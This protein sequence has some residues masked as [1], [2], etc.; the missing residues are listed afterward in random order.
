MTENFYKW[1]SAKCCRCTCQVWGS[2]TEFGQHKTEWCSTRFTTKLIVEKLNQ[3][4]SY[5]VITSSAGITCSPPALLMV[6]QM[7]QFF[8]ASSECLRLIFESSRE[9]ISCSR[10]WLTC[11]ADWAASGL[12][13]LICCCSR[14]RQEMLGIQ[15]RMSIPFRNSICPW[16]RLQMA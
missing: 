15:A 8:T 7:I 11:A 4:W 1:R 12:G 9:Y 5:R 10:R 13:F 16:C 2:D 3:R 6:K 14:K